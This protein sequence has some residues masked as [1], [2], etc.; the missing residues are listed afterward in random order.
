MIN[1]LIL[2]VSYS[3]PSAIL[4]N[5]TLY[6]SLFRTIPSLTQICDALVK[7]IQLFNWNQVLLITEEISFQSE[8]CN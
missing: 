1:I 4:S 7:L 3:S 2:Q 5:T 8:V 6:P